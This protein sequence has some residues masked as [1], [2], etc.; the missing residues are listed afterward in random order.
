MDRWRLK[1]CTQQ[2]QPPKF[3][4]G[5]LRAVEIEVLPQY[6]FTDNMFDIGY[7]WITQVARDPDSKKIVGSGIRV[8]DFELDERGNLNKVFLFEKPAK[9]EK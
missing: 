2:V 6:W 1:S 9:P 7:Q 3:T 8:P 5:G 4:F